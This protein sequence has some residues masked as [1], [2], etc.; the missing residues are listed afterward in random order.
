MRSFLSLITN[1]TIS[2]IVIVGF[3]FDFTLK[4]GINSMILNFKTFCKIIYLGSICTYKS[5]DYIFGFIELPEV[6]T[7]N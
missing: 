6:C 4:N 5:K 3:L 2:Q 1:G 7:F